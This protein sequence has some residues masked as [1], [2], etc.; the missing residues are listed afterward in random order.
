M[1]RARAIAWFVVLLI[2]ACAATSASSEVKYSEDAPPPGTEELGVRWARVTEPGIGVL[3]IAIARPSGDGPFPTIVL[4]HGSHGFA[5]EYVKLALALAQKGQLAVAACWFSEG[6]GAGSRFVTP[7]SC[8][9]APATSSPLSDG[10]QKTVAAI[11]QAVSELPDAAP[12]PVALFGHSRGGGATLK[13]VMQ[14]RN[15]RAAILNSTGYPAEVSNSVSRMDVPILI[16][17]GTAD[18]PADGGSAYT[19]VAMARNFEAAL[20][21]ASNPVEAVYY[22]KGCHNGIFDNA[23]QFDDEVRR[24]VT[25]LERKP[26]EQSGR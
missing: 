14:T 6:S 18:S 16:L 22:E 25:F 10:A 11:V 5:Q 1:T 4:L 8:P 12:G 19:S 24:I 3:P 9:Q 2:G 23:T 13:Y 17:H 20:R 7:I 15:A 21:T 26:L